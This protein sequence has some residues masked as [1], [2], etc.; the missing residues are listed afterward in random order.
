MINCTFEDGNT[1]SLRH[2]VVDTLVLKG[3]QILLVK[4]DPGLLEGGKWG[5]VG[6]YV[7]RDETTIEAA[8]RE[9]LEET[10]WEVDHIQLIRIKDWPDRPNEDRQNIAFVYV[11]NAVL[12][13][14]QPD[15]ESAEIKWFD[16]DKIPEKEE[17][18]FDHYQDMEFYLKEVGRGL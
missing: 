9:V 10:G 17:I 6:G 15:A 11:C 18:A 5:L 14:G 16:F 7:E 13:T 12:Q 1:N 8:K 3:N 4:R 2:V